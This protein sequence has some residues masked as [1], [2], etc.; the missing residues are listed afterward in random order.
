MNIRKIIREVFTRVLKESKVNVDFK[1]GDI[2]V[3]G[4][5]VGEM[6]VM[7]NNAGY[8]LLDKIFIDKDYRGMGYANDAMKQ[9]I[10][11]ANQHGKIIALTPDNVWKSS[12][13]RLTKWY[14]NLGFVMNKGRNK[15]FKTMQL[16]Y[17]LPDN[18]NEI[19]G[20]ESFSMKQV[21][22]VPGTFPDPK[23]FNE[24]GYKLDDVAR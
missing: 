10:D 12:K 16:M 7:E 4:V 19:S 9:L 5:K 3:D 2:T 18:L 13:A 11:Y 21:G 15:D 24:F 8:L 17:K 6:N 14:K 1:S 22:G 20:M 23:D